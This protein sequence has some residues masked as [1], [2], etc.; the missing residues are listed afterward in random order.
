M[1][2]LYFLEKLRTPL[3]NYLMLGITETGSETIFL[4]VAL[5][6]FWCVDKNYGY[7]LMG[8]GFAGILPNQILK[9]LLRIPRPWVLDPHFT[10]VEQ[11]RAGAGGFSFPSGHSQSSVG[12][13]GSL[14]ALYQD[15]RIRIPAIAL[16]ILI[17]FS[18]MYL[19][20]HTPKDVLFSAVLAVILIFVLRPMA[21]GNCAV[22]LAVMAGLSVIAAGFI[23]FYP[24]PADLDPESLAHSAKNIYDLMGAAFGILIVYH[25]DKNYLHFSVAA[26]LAFQILKTVFGLLILLAA[27]SLLKFPVAAVFGESPIGEALR[28]FLVV[29]MGGLGWP[30][31][32]T[33]ILRNREGNTP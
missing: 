5:V 18:R 23:S 17:P 30:W 22:P 14:A 20:V 27:K 19:G 16:C 31:I 8:V 32:F 24:F 15:K 13:Y 9:I 4:V 29:L 28:Y 26:P 25:A 33:R 11:A 7:Y 21:E 10:I 6:L 3:L 12:T 1:S 2:F